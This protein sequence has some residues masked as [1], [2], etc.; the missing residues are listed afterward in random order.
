MIYRQ[1][2]NGVRTLRRLER[3]L[4]QIQSLEQSGHVRLLPTLGTPSRRFETIAH[5]ALELL[6]EVVRGTV[7]TPEGAPLV[8]ATVRV[9]GSTRGALTDANGAFEVSVPDGA[10]TLLISYIGYETQ[11]ILIEG[12]SQ[13]DIVMDPTAN[14]LEEVVVIGFGTKKRRDVTG[15]ISSVTG[16][17]LNEIPV[18]SFEQALSGRAAGVQV[19]T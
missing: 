17:T 10:T 6:E 13:I 18:P 1:D 3:K 14:S 19:I 12:R 16:E 2:R 11:E 5:S 9:L 4:N 7:K 8:G 15:A